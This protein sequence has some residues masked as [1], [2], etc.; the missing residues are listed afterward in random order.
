MESVLTLVSEEAPA[1]GIEIKRNRMRRNFVFVLFGAW[2]VLTLAGVASGYWQ[3]S[4]LEEFQATGMIDPDEA[5]MSDFIHGG[6][7]ILQSVIYIATAVLFLMWFRRAYANLHRLGITYLRHKDDWAIWSWIIPILS[8]W[9]PVRIMYE[10]WN[11]T[12]EQAKKLTPNFQ[13]P[14]GKWVIGLWWTLF[15]ID[16]FLARILL[17][18]A[19]KEETLP[20]MIQSTE[21]M[22]ISDAIGVL[23]AASLICIVWAIGKMELSLV[24][25]IRRNGGRVAK[26]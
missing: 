1:A 5:T 25:G 8:F 18:S 10:I 9:Y 22:M 6:I 15:I 19:F 23:E 17:R 12:G 24:E 20:Q 13:I 21:L 2:A 16:N 7:G 14:E 3:V 4:L 11:E 26:D